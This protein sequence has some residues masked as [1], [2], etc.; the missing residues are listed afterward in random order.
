MIVFSS[1]KDM[2]IGFEKV[3]L[4]QNYAYATLSNYFKEAH[5]LRN[6]LL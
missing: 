6:G 3:L 2:K 4:I 1:H 5:S